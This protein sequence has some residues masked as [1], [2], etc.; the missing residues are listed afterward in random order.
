MNRQSHLQDLNFLIFVAFFDAAL[1]LPSDQCFA[2]RSNEASDGPGV[3]QS[4]CLVVRN[5]EAS[6]NVTKIR[7][8]RAWR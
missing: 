6:K 4:S 1:P 2:V 3:L 7:R 8:F 5:N